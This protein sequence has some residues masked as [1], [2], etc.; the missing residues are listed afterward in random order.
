MIKSSQSRWPTMALRFILLLCMVVHAAPAPA[1]L[2]AHDLPSDAPPAYDLPYFTPL[3][4]ERGRVNI[5]PAKVNGLILSAAGSSASS[6]SGNWLYSVAGQ[7]SP[8]GSVS[9]SSSS[10]SSSS[11]NRTL[12]S[13]YQIPENLFYTVTFS[14][15]SSGSSGS[16]GDHG[17]LDG[18]TLQTVLY[19]ANCTAVTAVAGEHHHFV[20]WSGD[21]TG[22]HNP[23]VIGHVTKNMNIVASFDI[24]R[25]TVSFSAGE[26]GSISGQALQTVPYGDD[27]TQVTATAAQG[28]H[29]TGW[30]GDYAGGDYTSVE[31][32]LIMSGVTADSRITANFAINTYTVTF[33]VEGH[34]GL[35]G[36]IV[37]SVTHGS[38]CTLVWAVPDEGFHFAGWRGGYAGSQNPL[39]IS[40]VTSDLTV[41]AAFA[42]DVCTLTIAQSGT[43]DGNIDPAFGQ[44]TYGRGAAV[45]LT[46]TALTGSAFSGWSGAA[47]GIQNPVTITLDSD[48]TIF[49]HFTAADEEGAAATLKNAPSG[50]TKAR[51]YTV[52][53]GGIG[54]VSYM[55]KIDNGTWSH[56]TEVSKP[57]SFS[58]ASK[59]ERY[60]YESHCLYVIGKDAQ[61]SWQPEDEATS[62]AWTV[63]T[64]PPTA[65]IGNCPAYTVGINWIDVFIGGAD[66]QFYKFMLDDNPWS[67]ARPVKTPISIAGLM[68]ATHTLAVIGADSAG[69]WQATANATRA[70]WSVDTTVPTAVLDDLPASVTREKSASIRV[71]GSDVG[72]YKYKLDNGYW[73]YRTVDEPIEL[74]GLTEGLHTLYVNA[75]HAENGL[76]QDSE[77]GEKTD[78]A[79]TFKW[80]VDTTPPS[81]PAL[82][83]RAGV[84]SSTAIELTWTASE[85]T[86]KS[87]RVWY[88]KTH[89]DPNNLS[90]AHEL[91]CNLIP[92]AS[93]L[94]ERFMV[95]GLSQNTTY[96]FAAAARDAAGNVSG[97]GAV[98]SLT[99]ASALP[100][101][102]GFALTA[103]GT[104]A[105]NSKAREFR[106]E[107]TNFI[108]A[109][110]DNRVRFINESHVFDVPSKAGTR[111]ELWADVPQ[112]SPVGV[113]R[114]RVVNKN[115]L[116]P[117]SSQT[118]TVT[119]A[120]VPY[121]EV[122]DIFPPV[123]R[124]DQDT[125][126][127]VTGAHFT[128]PLTARLA[129][130]D[131]SIIWDL[132][133]VTAED[134]RNSNSSTS[135]GN[136]SSTRSSRITA[137]VPSGAV[138]GTYHLLVETASGTN[139]VSA[140]RFEVYEP[141]DI[142]RATGAITSTEGVD[143]PDDGT[144]PVKLTLA[145][146]DRLEMTPVS[147]KNARIEVSLNPGTAITRGDGQPYTGTIDPPRQIPLTK[148][149]TSKLGH[150]AFA[151]SMGSTRDKL[152]L[153][154][155]QT[156]FAKIEVTLPA[157]DPVPYIYY[158]DSNG[159]FSL[160]GV[161]GEKDGQLIERG[162][163]VLTTQPDV[164][165]P[166]SVTYIFGLLLDH[167]STYV[168]G[169]KIAYE[170]N[171]GSLKQSE[172]A[173]WYQCFISAVS[174]GNRSGNT[175]GNSLGDSLGNT[176]GNSLMRIYD[177]CSQYLD[178]WI[179]KCFNKPS[180]KCS[181]SDHQ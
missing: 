145:T 147:E 71:G 164:P 2:A 34:G 127:T 134:Q 93:G 6:G 176:M 139:M 136:N 70:V 26:H 168:A 67:A 12:A 155:G 68:P 156:M 15:S 167:M 95:K 138:A 123:G 74:T 137:T 4:R 144:V 35:Q 149:M 143:M 23:L 66:V 161:E 3:S 47:V 75:Q 166:G 150:K 121:P 8:L 85:D 88:S 57:F 103:G 141:F 92:G 151:F 158:V 27:C 152:N 101:I 54:V 61:G 129:S 173:H 41:T 109:A 38:G 181:P 175:L 44:Y 117:L 79:T 119:E 39:V 72:N 42:L 86:L 29:F 48:K 160:A 53:V 11:G 171:G 24:D 7:P 83:A 142:T 178:V 146:D 128:E 115:G 84:P 174:P 59:E 10:S 21:Y 33:A 96:Y 14:S 97:P 36:S 118:Y 120:P 51:D 112:G 133:E 52:R 100:T 18:E 179:S 125:A 73:T 169:S 16:P 165:E 111:T 30:S 46:A 172:A 78:S 108:G 105:D 25:Y 1:V 28:Y 130:E 77:T 60:L 159:T 22:T 13:G 99:T 106:V 170:E 17:T 162:G 90:T 82:T 148:E 69:N 43:G 87:Y 65:T 80:T 154:F 37:Q 9:P 81:A 163:T 20:G 132:T 102:T 157:S 89:I 31:N 5:Y 126:I 104:E 55:W 56:E 94:T 76:W 110:G 50:I 62:C 40:N 135:D 124:N 58:I 91:Y 180:G 98:A 45:T 131:G 19:D 64:T 140:I 63:D 113:Y 114:L 32:P 177:A 49:V 153:G 122:T 116:T 107:G